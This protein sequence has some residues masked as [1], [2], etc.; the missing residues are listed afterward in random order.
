M[1]RNMTT[2][3]SI[4]WYADDLVHRAK[5]RKI[6]L[7]K[8]QASDILELLKKNHDA[9]IGINWEVVDVVTDMYLA[10]EL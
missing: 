5:E 1:R 8:E 4:K 10:D 3:I 9:S 2:E 6:S 7:S